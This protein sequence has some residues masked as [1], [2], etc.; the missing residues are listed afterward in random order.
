M[1]KEL[2]YQIIKKNTYKTVCKTVTTNRTKYIQN[3]A[4]GTK[5]PNN[6]TEHIQNG[7]QSTN[8]TTN[9]NK[10]SAKGT[11]V[12]NTQTHHIKNT[13]QGTNVTNHQRNTLKTVHKTPT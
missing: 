5:V 8:V 11:N 3:S 13:A 2:T 4:R 7:A 10:D 12:P 6:H 1:S 9:L